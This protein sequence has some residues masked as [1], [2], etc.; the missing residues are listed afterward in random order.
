MVSPQAVNAA[1][2]PLLA[3]QGDWREA[4]QL[5]IA[6]RSVREL[7]E[8]WWDRVTAPVL[9][10]IALAQGEPAV[11]RDV[12]RTHL[13][14]GPSTESGNVYFHAGLT[15]QRVAAML[16]LEACDF[17]TARA[18]LLAHD[19]W[20]AWNGAVL[21]QAEGAAIWASFYRA[22]GD[23]VS[24]RVHAART[25]PRIGSASAARTHDGS[26]LLG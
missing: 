18:W 8:A 24:A 17:S 16:S 5:A 21:G 20:L 1:R 6:A 7:G 26:S 13:P 19:R 4:R 2:L 12:I 25:G 22:S 14:F 23:P 15:L 10:S 3:L 9:A 11:A